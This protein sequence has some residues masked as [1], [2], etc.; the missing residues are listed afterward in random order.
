MYSDAILQTDATARVIT[1]QDQEEPRATR[2]VGGNRSLL[3]RLQ[4]V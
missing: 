3:S 4:P 1:L 2:K